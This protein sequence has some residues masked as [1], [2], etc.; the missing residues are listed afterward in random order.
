MADRGRALTGPPTQVVA[1]FHETLDFDEEDEEIHTA[2]RQLVEQ[3]RE[4]WTPQVDQAAFTE[5]VDNLCTRI[6]GAPPTPVTSPKKPDHEP[7]R[8]KSV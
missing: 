5:T 4:L 7:R 2:M 6:M 8:P 3:T 1:V